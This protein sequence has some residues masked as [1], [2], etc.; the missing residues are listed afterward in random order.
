MP[1]N[2]HRSGDERKVVVASMTQGVSQ[3]SLALG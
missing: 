3:S 2:R 1:T